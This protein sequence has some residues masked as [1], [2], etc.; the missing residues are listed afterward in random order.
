MDYKWKD[1]LPKWTSSWLLLNAEIWYKW[2]TNEKIAK[3]LRLE[4]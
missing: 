3:L 4:L 2:T 1:K